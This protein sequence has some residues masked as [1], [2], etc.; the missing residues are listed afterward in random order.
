MNAYPMVSSTFIGREMAGLEQA[1][2][3]I[4]RYACRRWDGELVDPLDRAEA[5]STDYLLDDGAIALALGFLVSLIRNP[6]GTLRAVRLWWRLLRA[7]GGFVRHVAY[8]LEAVALYHRL[9]DH[10]VAHI[11]AHFST[12]GAAVAMMTKALG[13]PG[14]SFTVHGPDELFDPV[15]NSLGLKIQYADFVACISHFCRSQCMIF[16]PVDAW[17][18]LRIVHCGVRPADYTAPPPVADLPPRA[19]GRRILYVG[20]L[21]QLK[22]GLV[23]IAAMA[24]VAKAH[25]EAD[26][27]VVG[28]GEVR[29][30]MEARAKAMGLAD[31]VHFLGFRSQGDVR[32][33]M[34]DADVFTLP[35]F[36]EG[37]PVVFMEAM[38]SGIPVVA[39]QVAGVSELVEE[40]V[41]GFIVP[42]GD[43]TAL[44]RRVS[45]LL[46]DPALRTRMGA[47]GAARVAAD[48]NIDIETIWLGELIAAAGSGNSLPSNLRPLETS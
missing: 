42:P 22:G 24:D 3:Q 9:R 5:K 34:A 18:R 28:D 17:D 11:H 4:D 43:A 20:R 45:D 44:A 41:S 25:P 23:L 6:G 7:G 21:S 10:P 14:Y 46:S 30:R 19:S 29:A 13:G 15:G 16:A 8:L 40:G 31:R 37:V 33:A 48:F 32:A 27:V 38:A 12:N 26:L 36:A 39:T 47:A 1:G 2:F 35:S